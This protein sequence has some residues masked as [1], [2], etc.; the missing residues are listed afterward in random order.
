[1]NAMER[2]KQLGQL[3]E[4]AEQ[5]P[6]RQTMPH[7]TERLLAVILT[8]LGVAV[9]VLA[10]LLPEELRWLP[11]LRGLLLT[12][13]LAMGFG[14]TVFCLASLEQARNQR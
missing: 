12:G 13:L 2:L 1:M 9:V 10:L 4:P 7:P 6:R 5:P 11:L 3:T 8:L 14:V